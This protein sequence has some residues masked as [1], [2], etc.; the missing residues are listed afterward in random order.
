MFNG[1]SRILTM[2]LIK[3][4][5]TAK[6]APVAIS[7]DTPFSKVSPVAIWETTYKV[8][9][10]TRSVRKIL[11]IP[12]SISRPLFPCQMACNQFMMVNT[13]KAVGFIAD[14]LKKV[15]GWGGIKPDLR[16]AARSFNHNGFKPFG[17]ANKRN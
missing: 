10:S 17:K 6:I 5:A 15:K 9:D 1:K 12:L 8:P 16:K 7:V 3:K 4:V 13:G 11:F 2:G 14:S